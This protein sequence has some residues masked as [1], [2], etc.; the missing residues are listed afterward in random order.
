MSFTP[1]EDLSDEELYNLMDLRDRIYE[2]R[3]YL[4]R[5]KGV[6]VAFDLKN[7]IVAVSNFRG[8]EEAYA[9]AIIRG[10]SIPF[11]TRGFCVE[12]EVI[13]KHNLLLDKSLEKRAK[14]DLERKIRKSA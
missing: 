9:K 13:D 5:G 11:V 1:V 7:R 8:E 10:C 4:Y 14:E 6:H 12:R 3:L 2:S